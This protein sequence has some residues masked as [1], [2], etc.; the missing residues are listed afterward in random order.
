MKTRLLFHKKYLLLFSLYFV[1]ICF[2]KIEANNN[3]ET[4]KVICLGNS[5]T[6]G[7]PVYP[8]YPTELA[9]LLDE[10]YGKG[11]FIVENYGVGGTTLSK[12]G[13]NP[14]WNQEAFKQ[15]QKSDPNIVI[16]KFGTND[17]KP[18]NWPAA[19]SSYADDI[20]EIVSIFRNLPSLPKVYLG[21]PTWVYQDVYNIRSEEL[22]KEITPI[23]RNTAK[24]LDVDTID[25]YTPLKEH[26]ELYMDGVHLTKAG[27][28]VLAQAAF[29]VITKD[30][31]SSSKV[32]QNQVDNYIIYPLNATPG[33]KINIK[34]E[35][36]G[37][38]VINIYN[39]Y[40]MN[41]K[42]V[43]LNS[44]FLLIDAP[45]NTGIYI[46]KISDKTSSKAF[47]LLVK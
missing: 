18:A 24:K 29:E 47:K 17:S 3:L 27:A 16:I 44:N 2:S 15:A 22:E 6:N 30:F 40:G 12:I 8:P 23:I 25:F 37:T 32:E 42:N 20:E 46:L 38:K 7:A 41:I 5:I 13:N 14:Y 1:A 19:E 31:N 34:T 4:L 10:K 39:S 28:G 43:A 11:A 21:I 35:H 9:T 45:N 36:T 26:S 33:E